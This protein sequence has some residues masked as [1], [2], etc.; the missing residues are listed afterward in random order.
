MSINNN[1]GNLIVISGPS[2]VGKGTL[3]RALLK[4]YSD[5]DYS[6]SATTRKPRP[7]EVH[8]KEY[9]FYSKEDFE[10]LIADNQLLE[11]AK[12]YNNYYGTPI[13]YV[14]EVIDKR[15]DCILEIDVQGAMKVKSKWSEGV[16]IFIAPPSKEELIRR[17][18]FRGTESDQE[19]KKRMSQTDEEMRCISNYDYVVVNDDIDKAVESIRAIIVAERCNITRLDSLKA[20][21]G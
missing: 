21:I 20:D 4:K 15:K 5:I 7:G 12:V 1:K 2:G 17:I 13:D 8:G 19:I 16:F 14:Q 3:C 9:W 11:W 6:V 10:K 18:T